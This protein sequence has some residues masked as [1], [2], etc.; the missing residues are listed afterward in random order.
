MSIRWLVFP[1]WDAIP[2][3][4]NLGSPYLQRP[5]CKRM[6]LTHPVVMHLLIVSH[7]PDCGRT[8]TRGNANGYVCQQCRI[9]CLYRHAYWQPLVLSRF[10]S[11]F[12]C[13]LLCIKFMCLQVFLT[14]TSLNN[15]HSSRAWLRWCI[16]PSPTMYLLI[17]SLRVSYSVFYHKFTEIYDV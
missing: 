10:V 14:F 17:F 3:T 6:L 8:H 5:G 15:I 12:G 11:A 2:C 4:Y 9:V 7:N 1:R 13:E 16:A